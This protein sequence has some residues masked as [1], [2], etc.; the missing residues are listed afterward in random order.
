[1]ART[2]PTTVST[3]P[4]DI[5]QTHRSRVTHVSANPVSHDSQV[6]QSSVDIEHVHFFSLSPKM[7]HVHQSAATYSIGCTFLPFIHSGRQTTATMTSASSAD[8][9]SPFS[10]LLLSRDLASTHHGDRDPPK[11]LLKP[12]PEKLDTMSLGV[13]CYSLPVISES[14]SPRRLPNR[15]VKTLDWNGMVQCRHGWTL[16]RF[17]F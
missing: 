1:V 5:V 6:V 15:T 13:S 3:S 17:S 10:S 12:A 7:L 14:V 16:S 9:D 2:P 8:H 4:L 11:V